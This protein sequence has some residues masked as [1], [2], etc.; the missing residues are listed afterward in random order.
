MR[1]FENVK[2]IVIKIGTNVLTKKGAVRIDT[3]YIRRI[4]GQI[5]SLIKDG[6]QVVIVVG[7]GKA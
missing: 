6:R 7:A 3:S 1:N 5:S 2:K 4:A